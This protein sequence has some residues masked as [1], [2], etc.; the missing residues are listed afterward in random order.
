M[1]GEMNQCLR[2]CQCAVTEDEYS[3][4]VKRMAEF[5]TTNG[6]GS[7]AALTTARDRACEQMDFETAAQIH[8]RVEKVKAASNCRDEV[9]SEIDQFHGV[10]L[11][12]AAGNRQ[13]RLWPMFSG[14]WQEPITLDFSTEASGSRSLSLDAQIR[15]QL[16]LCVETARTTG[17]R[18]EELAIFSRWYFSSWRDGSWFP[19][20]NLDEFNYRRL[21][22]EISKA[23]RE[24][25]N[26]PSSELTAW[27]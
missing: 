15:E 5:L 1:Y 25:P 7:I 11:T 26:D 3:S 8:K 18:A 4:E 17:E 9:V 23:N 16:S 20:R 12:S 19:F 22:R 13:F 6:K 27:K 2:P 14:Y 24:R 10:A 21:V